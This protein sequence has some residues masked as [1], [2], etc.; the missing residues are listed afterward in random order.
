MKICIL[1]QMIEHLLQKIN[2]RIEIFTC[3]AYCFRSEM[4]SVTHIYDISVTPCF[5]DP[6]LNRGTCR[7]SGSSYLCSCLPGYT[8]TSC[9]GKIS[10][11]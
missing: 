10:V 3:T 11:H 7:V 4:Q 6:C 5:G 2:E 9:E 1:I 8:G